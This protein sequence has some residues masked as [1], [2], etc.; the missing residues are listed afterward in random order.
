M[1][2]STPVIY[3]AGAIGGLIGAYTQRAGNDVLLVDKAEDHVAHMNQHGLHVFGN[4]GDFTVPV[5]AA[6]PDALPDNLGLVF[7]A[8]KG[9]DTDAALDVIVPKLAASG[10]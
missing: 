2:N 3:G 4:Y 1:P 5:S 10:A 7:L 6:T 9:Q 8:V